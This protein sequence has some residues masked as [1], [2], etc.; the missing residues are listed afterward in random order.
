MFVRRCCAVLVILALCVPNLFAQRVAL[1]VKGGTLGGG[2]ELTAGLTESLN[3]RI[4]GNFLPYSLTG[5]YTEEE[6]DIGYTGDLK[7]QT[8]SLLLDWHPFANA[9][10]LSGGAVYNGIKVDATA[11]P[12]TS[13]T[14]KN[15]TFS[16]ED[17]GTLS[18]T[19]DYS[20]KLAPYAGLGFGNAVRGSRI[21]VTLDVGVMYTNAP[22]LQMEGTGMI[23][24]TAEQ[25]EEISD[26]FTDLKLY[27]VVSLGLSVGL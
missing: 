3:L 19:A 27:P 2:A 16:K 20:S 9:F 22:R 24:P 7:M 25:D 1:G 11:E 4:G 12:L 15:R 26:A 14:V 8:A 6:V 10:R 18:G 5:E 17:L 13:Y 21:D 23:A